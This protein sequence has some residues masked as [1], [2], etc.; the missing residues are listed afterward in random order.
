[1]W[2]DFVT[3][4]I[5]IYAAYRGAKKGFLWQVATIAGIVIC[6]L[7]ATPV[8][9]V[10]A[11]MI[12]VEAPLNRWIAIF[13]LYVVSSFLL[14]GMASGLRNWLT[15]IKFIE[16]D[17]HLGGM[18]GLLKGVAFCVVLTFFGLTLSTSVRDQI[19]LSY[20]GYGSAWL[21]T[22]LDPVM[23][24]EFKKI[25]APY[26]QGLT[27][28]A[29]AEARK[30][31]LNNSQNTAQ[32][33]SNPITVPDLFPIGNQ[34]NSNTNINNSFPWN[35]SNSNT[36]TTNNG[37]SV[38]QA[39][40]KAMI[41]EAMKKLPLFFTQEMKDAIR[42]TLENASESQRV[43]LLKRLQSATPIGLTQLAT[44][45]MSMAPKTPN[46]LP[47]NAQLEANRIALKRKIAEQYFDIVSVQD[48]IVSEMDAVFSGLPSNVVD[49]VLNDWY[50]DLANDHRLSAIKV[51]DPDP[52]TDAL[53]ALNTRI[54][55]QLTLQNISWNSLSYDV[56]RR[57]QDTI[58]R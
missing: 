15:K 12:G 3:A 32:N 23:P 37:T 5:L 50:I 30:N 14:Y 10:L 38:T 47:N 34:P 52:Q 4:G 42:H 41:D 49:G 11:P 46:S 16:Y 39:A 20:T 54:A 6:F 56:Q 27:P 44:Q 55:R 31:Q 29:I 8:S 26:T 21:L 40:Q 24:E 51:K 35:V 25:I 48:E 36:G 18:F 43:E 13:I 7:F 45:I 1:M 19:M 58:Q 53:V 22:Q 2:F 28:E 33:G 57:I 17:E 9:L